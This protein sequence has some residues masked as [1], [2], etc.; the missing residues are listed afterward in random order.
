MTQFKKGDAVR[1]KGMWNGIID[2]VSENG[3][4]IGISGNQG[5]FSAIDF[6]LLLPED[7]E[8]RRSLKEVL[9]EALSLCKIIGSSKN[10]SK[11]LPIGASMGMYL[12]EIARKHQIGEFQINP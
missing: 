3:K 1:F 5:G 11:Q 12:E 4:W 7:K 2:S 9:T 10:L 6:E 8:L